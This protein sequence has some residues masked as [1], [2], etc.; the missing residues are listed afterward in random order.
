M[1]PKITDFV[2]CNHLY[3]VCQNVYW[4]TI[5]QWRDATLLVAFL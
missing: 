4:G 1:K 2:N 5:N 3:S